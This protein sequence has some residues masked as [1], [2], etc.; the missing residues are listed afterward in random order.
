MKIYKEFTLKNG[1]KLIVRSAEKEDA[2]E[3][4][5]LYKKTATETAYLSRGEGDM[6]PTVE[7]FAD[8][9]QYYLEDARNCYLVAIYEGKMVGS[10]H[11]D[12]CGNKKRS[13]HRCDINMGVLKNFWNLGIG[14]RLMMTLL[15]VAKEAGFEQVELSVA[16]ANLRAMLMYRSFG[17]EKCGVIPKAMKY[18]DGT[19]LDMIQ[20]VKFL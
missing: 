3:E 8:N 1:K 14:G 5:D 9:Y 20:M 13:L 7:D 19:Y 16:S 4:L 11:L 2:Q 12:Y 17:F 15:E 10:A 6:F 18:E